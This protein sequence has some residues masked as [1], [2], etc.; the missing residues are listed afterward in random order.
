MQKPLLVIGSA[1]HDLVVTSPRLPLPG[2]TLI[3]SGFAT[4]FGGK[5]ANQAVAAARLGAQVFMIGAVGDD[6]VGPRILEGLARAGVRTDWMKT[7]PGDSGVA[8][9][10]HAES[11][12]NAIVIAPGANSRLLPEDI[13]HN[14]DRIAQ[15][16]TVLLQMEVP[17]ATVE[18]AIVTA[19]ELH[20]PVVLDP[21]PARALEDRLLRQITWLTPNETEQQ[22][23]LAQADAR[24][25]EEAAQ[26]LLSRGVRNVALKLGGRGVFIAGHDCATQHIP[27]F[28]VP[29]VDTTAA[30]DVFNAAFACSL[31]DGN[32]AD[33]AALFA[34]AASAI[35][36]TRAGAQP[37]IPALHEVQEFLRQRTT[38]SALR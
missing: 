5:G 17:F 25:P 14:R 37:S 2:E 35:S 6:A 20:V 10:F 7:V 33:K 3:G 8:V 32:A 16:G 26:A 11:G 1:S 22:T 9:I 29:V 21:A 27:A 18:R 13:D 4:F 31:L 23:L 30:G 36:V 15:A 38:A 28:P 12:E 34:V 24:T 19:A